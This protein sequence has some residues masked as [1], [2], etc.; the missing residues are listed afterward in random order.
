MKSIQRVLQGK[1]KPLTYVAPSDTVQRALELM[2]ER[3]IGAVLVLDNGKLVGIFTERD[4]AQ[5]V[6]LKGLN[7]KETKVSEVMTD[8][9][10]FVTTEQTVSQCLA[11]MTERFFRHLPVLDKD[12]N[13]IG[14]VSIGDLVKEKLS[15]QSFIIDQMERYITS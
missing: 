5:K 2:S 7:I 3:D 8:K 12:Q 1:S 13:V 9:V 4:C 14:I 10:R 15:E 6:S 11:L